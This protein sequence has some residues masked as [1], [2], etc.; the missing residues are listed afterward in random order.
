MT[1]MKASW[2]SLSQTSASLSRFI[3]WKGFWKQMAHLGS[4]RRR[5]LRLFRREMMRLNSC[6]PRA[7]VGI[8]PGGGGVDGAGRVVAAA[9][10]AACRSSRFARRSAVSALTA[11]GLL[12]SG[13]C[14]MRAR[15]T[16][17]VSSLRHQRPSAAL[18]KRPVEHSAPRMAREQSPRYRVLS[19][20]RSCPYTAAIR[21]LMVSSESGAPWREMSLQMRPGRVF[22]GE[23]SS[24]ES[25][26]SRTSDARC[27]ASSMSEKPFS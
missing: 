14:F 2:P 15:S 24:R 12:R 21:S 9:A 26:V 8:S 6:R 16:R 18:W 3:D 20:L 7:A 5:L 4:P 1:A 10:V 13:R 25:P 23:L 27:L 19:D 11:R 17:V 22:H